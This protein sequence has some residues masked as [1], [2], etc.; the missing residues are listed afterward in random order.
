[1]N[2]LIT[3][4]SAQ[5]DPWVET[6][7]A[8]GVNAIAFPLIEVHS[9]IDGNALNQSWEVYKK[10]RALMFVSSNAV[11]FFFHH[12]SKDCRDKTFP[13]PGQRLWA[14]GP[15]TAKVLS[16]EGIHTSV[17]DAPNI[18][19]AKFDSEALW[20][21]VS[22]QVRV[23]DRV[24]IVRGQD[25]LAIEEVS[26]GGRDFLTQAICSS[27]ANVDFLE[28]YK[29]IPPALSVNQVAVA[30]K[31]ANDGSLWL[32]SSGQALYHLKHL[33]PFQ[34]W[35]NA[36]AL[37]THPRIALVAEGL[38]FGKVQTCRPVLEDVLASIESLL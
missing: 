32:F 10:Y 18:D 29:R 15:G 6:L 17:V 30:E 1:M 27:G 11:K 9:L 28:V 23:K 12:C 7:I 3:R 21:L 20:S 25:I 2:V 8:Q 16:Q 31:S 5:A 19:M 14:T 38:G 26:V 4:P 13:F 33:L 34:N 36:N 22:S 35:S 24:L 37:V